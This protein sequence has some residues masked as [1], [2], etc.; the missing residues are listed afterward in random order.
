MIGVGCDAAVLLDFPLPLAMYKKV[1]G[2]ELTLRDLSD[3]DPTLGRSLRAVLDYAGALH[4]LQLAT[5]FGGLETV[6]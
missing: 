5:Y 4:S 2:Q 6:V 3:F 1:L